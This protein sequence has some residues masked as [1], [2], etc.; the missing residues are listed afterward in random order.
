MAGALSGLLPLRL[1]GGE[2]ASWLGISA[3]PEQE[4]AGDPTPPADGMSRGLCTP[5]ASVRGLGTGPG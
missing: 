4:S 1:L 2:R 5:A 3:F